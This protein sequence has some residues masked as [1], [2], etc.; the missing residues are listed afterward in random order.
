MRTFLGTLIVA[1]LCSLILIYI[2]RAVPG[3]PL[4]LLPFYFLG[5]AASGNVHAPNE[6]VT[7]GSL[8]LTVWLSSYG[9][10]AALRWM[11]EK[12]GI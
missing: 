2:A 10:F 12:A 7:Y 11:K 5:A 3:Y 4:L 9:I 8:F 6:M 1:V